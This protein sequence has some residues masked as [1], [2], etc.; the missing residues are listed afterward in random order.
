MRILKIDYLSL[1]RPVKSLSGGEKQRLYLLSKLQTKIE[2]TLI[3]IEN[4]SFGLSRVELVAMCEFL[5]GLV[6]S[7]NTVVIIDKNEI[8]ENVA[9]NTILFS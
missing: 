7:K 8:F 9:S 5:Q 4:V 6:G 1:D 3:I 2:N